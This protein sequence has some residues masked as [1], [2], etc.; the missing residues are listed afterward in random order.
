MNYGT[1]KV[2][3]KTSDKPAAATAKKA[4]PQDDEAATLAGLSKGLQTIHNLRTLFTEKKQDG[5][6]DGAEKFANGALSE[7]L[8]KKDSQVWSTIETML[9]A[10]QDAMKAVKGKSK[11]ERKELM[12]S[13]ENKLDKKAA[14]LSVVTDDVNKKQ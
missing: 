5:P 14:D 4:K 13:L 7:E 1:A 8:S 3:T 2:V 12:K 11:S 6:K 10:T 9:G